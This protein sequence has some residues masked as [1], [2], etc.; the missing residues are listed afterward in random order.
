M[1][2]RPGERDPARLRLWSL[3][4]HVLVEVAPEDDHL[5]AVTRWGDIRIDDASDVVRESLRR[6]SLGPASVENLPA[7]RESFLRW[8]GGT[9]VGSAEPWARFQ[10]VLET[11]GN[12]VVQSLGIEDGTGPVLSVVPVSRQAK[13]FLP[14][15]VGRR[16]VRLSRFA[17]FRVEG[18]EGLV[19]SPLAAHRVL[20]HRPLAAWV[21]SSLSGPT[22]VS[23]LARMLRSPEALVA[24]IVSYLVY[25][26]TVVVGEQRPADPALV[27]VDPAGLAENSV[28]F[29]EDHDPKLAA[30]SPYDLLFHARSRM[31]WLGPDGDGAECDRPAPPDGT[32]GPPAVG[33]QNGHPAGRTGGHPA[34]PANGL[35]ETVYPLPAAETGAGRDPGAAEWSEQ[36]VTAEQL[37]RLLSRVAATPWPGGPPERTRTG[38]GPAAGDLDELAFYVALDRCPGLP[39]GCFRYDASRHALVLVNDSE[40]DTAELLDLAAVAAG[41]ARRPPVVITV[42]SRIDRLS[43]VP[44]TL[45]YTTTLRHV[46]AVQQ[47]A[48]REA[49][50]LGL[51]FRALAVTDGAVA[52][53]TLRLHWP[54]EVS[55]GEL[56]IGVRT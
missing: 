11:L 47:I 16:P 50:A 28:V 56:L 33:G 26:G 30:W 36:P 49:A 5:V 9:K 53:V 10:R 55:V 7:L 6:M 14:K 27:A 34:G 18:G 40:A 25:S 43:W 52:D 24:E 39:R 15:E 31:E 20:L 38:R 46:G 1:T 21:V 4:E 37:G 42:T 54:V 12:S 8:R 32:G 2:V 41:S 35:P 22:T 17:C 13:F 51:A 44:T 23:E 19:E 48:A 45:S 29:A 3:S